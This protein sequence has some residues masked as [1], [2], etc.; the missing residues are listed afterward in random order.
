MAFYWGRTLVL[1]NATAVLT[2]GVWM[3]IHSFRR[4]NLSKLMWQI[5]CTQFLTHSNPKPNQSP[6]FLF[7]TKLKQFVNGQEKGKLNLGTLKYLYWPCLYVRPKVATLVP[8]T[9]RQRKSSTIIT[10][11]NDDGLGVCFFP[12]L[13][14]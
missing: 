7:D 10:S 1:W 12:S 9:C 8:E 11:F 14:I 2:A 6:S 4:T 5:R 3:R 13:K